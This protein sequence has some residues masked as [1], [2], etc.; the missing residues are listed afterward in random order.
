[1]DTVGHVCHDAKH[2]ASMVPDLRSPDK[3]R[4]ADYWRQHITDGIDGTLM[5]AFAKSKDGILSNEQ[6]ES[7]VKFLAGT[8]MVPF[9]TKQ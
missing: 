6:I 9:S 8:P 1:M 7:L 3:S 2:R 4:D 5:P